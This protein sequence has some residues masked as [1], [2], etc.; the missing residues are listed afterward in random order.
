VAGDDDLFSL[1][2]PEVPGK[3]V[4][5]FG[6]RDAFHRGTP[7]SRSQA[8]DCSFVTIVR[9]CTSAPTTDGSQKSDPVKLPCPV[10]DAHD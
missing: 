1:R 10:V 3:V 9:I 5:N 2:Q 6:Q 8:L 4:L 7:D